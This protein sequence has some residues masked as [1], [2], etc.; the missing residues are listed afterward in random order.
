MRIL[1]SSQKRGITRPLKA[2]IHW[3]SAIEPAIGHMK[4][5]GRL[6]RPAQGRARRC[7]A[8]GDVQHNLR[9][10]L[11]KLRLLDARFGLASRVLLTAFVRRWHAFSSRTLENSIVQDGLPTIRTRRARA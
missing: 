8:C 6:G 1:R 10:I 9:L 11:A 7:A 4:M 3:R 5:D 2:M